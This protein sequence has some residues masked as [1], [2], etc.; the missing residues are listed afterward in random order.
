[1]DRVVVVALVGGLVGE[2][3]RV[4]EVEIVLRADLVELLEALDAGNVGQRLACREEGF[5]LGRA[6]RML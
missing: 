5:F 3:H 4:A 1:M 2:L 6:A